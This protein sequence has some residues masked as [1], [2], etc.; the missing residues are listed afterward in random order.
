MKKLKFQ[1][2]Q[3][4]KE[5]ERKNLSK[6]RLMEIKTIT[7]KIAELIDSQSDINYMVGIVDEIYRGDSKYPKRRIKKVIQL[8][9]D[10]VN[11]KD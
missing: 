10:Y 4:C 5:L 11:E 7:L 2:S 1:I 9:M 3:L 6:E 8:L